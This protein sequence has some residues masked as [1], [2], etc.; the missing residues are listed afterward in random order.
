MPPSGLASFVR[1]LWETHSTRVRIRTIAITPSA[2]P[3]LMN[4]PK[5][6]RPELLGI[7]ALV[8]CAARA[9][10]F[11]GLTSPTALRTLGR[12]VDDPLERVLNAKKTGKPQRAG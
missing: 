5:A 1:K 7:G 4:S 6:P 11:A 2:I 10:N 3:P 8:L 9:A 12:A